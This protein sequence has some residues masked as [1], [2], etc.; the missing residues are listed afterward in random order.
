MNDASRRAIPAAPEP[1]R[2]EKTGA[3]G[4][5][6][7]LALTD[8]VALGLAF[9]AGFLASDWIRDAFLAEPFAG[10]AQDIMVRTL[11]FAAIALAVVAVFWRQAHYSQRR[12][13]WDE[14]YEVL[15][16][17][18]LAAFADA[19][20][21][22]MGKWYFSRLWWF[23]TWAIALVLLPFLR[24]RAKRWLL[25]SGHWVR[26]TA[27]FGTGPNAMEALVALRSEPLMGYAVTAF[28]APPVPEGAVSTKSAIDG[29]IPVL[30]LSAEPERL[31]EAHGIDALVVAL[32]ADELTEHRALVERLAF[33]GSDVMLIPPIRG[34]PLY[35]MDLAH[36]FRHEV[37]LL[38]VPNNLERAGAQ[39]VKRVFDIMCSALGLVLLSPL[40]LYIA[41]RV[42]ATG[43]QVI[44]A[45]ERVGRRGETFSC[46]KFRTMV[47]DADRVLADLVARDPNARAE[48]ERDFKLK[49]DPRITA[50]GRF[51]RATSLDE[52]PQLWNVLRGEM[53]LVGP[54]PV[55][56]AELGRYGDAL[57]YY[58]GSRPGITGLWQI[59]GRNDLDYPE[60]VALDA[61][62][63]KNWSLWYD[64]VILVKTIGVVLEREG[65]Y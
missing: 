36:F 32:E 55:V 50:I 60:R 62:Y 11:L 49:D 23:A 47:P 8:L 18:A 10:T 57:R 25:R 34:L 52:L 33:H 31:L 17:V 2:T 39:F 45:H 16:I 42:R 40:L 4:V 22:F 65:A 20:L 51:L 61:W 58:L 28:L 7:A 15:R 6:F 63:I 9:G 21:V 53:S 64:V 5:G 56:N 48:W 59:S 54:R 19:A 37:L 43:R 12:T 13:F 35:G 30:T 24:V 3:A 46:Y 38:R 44:F 41:L 26:K 14:L 29:A 1:R 27:I